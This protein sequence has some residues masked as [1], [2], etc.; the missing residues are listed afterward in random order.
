MTHMHI[1]NPARP[2]MH[3]QDSPWVTAGCCLQSM[4]N[5]SLQSSSG[6]QVFCSRNE[7]TEV[8]LR[9]VPCEGGAALPPLQVL[10]A[11]KRL[12]P[13]LSWQ[14]MLDLLRLQY[15]PHNSA[16]QQLLAALEAEVSTSSDAPALTLQQL[17][18]L[19]VARNVEM[20]KAEQDRFAAWTSKQV[21]SAAA[22]AAAASGVAATTA[23][24]PR[25][26]SRVSPTLCLAATY[27]QLR[28][29]H[30]V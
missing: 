9:M 5:T 30:S 23:A 22:T 14:H 29:P 4:R 8:G 18:E 6:L 13:S 26:S 15:A 2:Y 7:D 25:R 20:R 16:V 1:C 19:V 12:R 27:R 24:A 3:W 10:Q 28:R 17:L 21:D 11:V